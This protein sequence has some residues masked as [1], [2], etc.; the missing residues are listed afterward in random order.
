[1]PFGDAQDVWERDGAL[2]RLTRDRGQWRYDLSRG[3]SLFWLDVDLVSGAM[4]Y[5]QTDPAERVAVV[6]SAIDD[7]ALAVLG[8][9]VRHSP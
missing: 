5:A 6:S 8:Q 7:R 2:I 1:V 3:G 4:G 9:A